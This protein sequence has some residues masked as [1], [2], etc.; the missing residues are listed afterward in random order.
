MDNPR[1]SI[2]IPAYN[3]YPLL[4]EAVES[5][6]AQSFRDYELIVVDDGS[7]D[8]TPRFRNDEDV[9]YLQIPHCGMPGAVRNRGVEGA[10]GEYIA[11]L[12][13]DD[14]WLPEKLCRQLTML[15]AQPAVPLVHT[16]EF[17][18]RGAKTVSQKGQKHAR[19]GNI[20]SDALWKCTIG[21]ST[22]LMRK[23]VFEELGGFDE[24]LEVAEDYEFWLRVTSR[25]PVAYLDEALTVK[26]AGDWEQLSEKHGQIE[27]FRIEAL[28]RLLEQDRLPR[29]RRPE[30]LA[31]LKRKIRIWSSG[32][33]KRGR[34]IEAKA[35]VD[36]LERL[37]LDGE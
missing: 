33:I 29:D 8:D 1:V 16:R 12:D 3:R 7:D 10:Q 18:R 36:R 34:N 28:F 22:V 26:R 2:I 23:A 4:T 11:F 30:T 25:Y 6:K 24:S 31:M 14:L 17:W 35:F 21:P 19:E 5:V 27:G 20:F 32:A 37:A 15:D 13:S 9:R